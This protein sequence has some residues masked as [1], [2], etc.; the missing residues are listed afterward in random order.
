M[1]VDAGWGNWLEIN[2]SNWLTMT[3]KQDWGGL[4]YYV[5][6][7]NDLLS[8]LSMCCSGLTARSFQ[9]QGI[10]AFLFRIFHVLCKK[11]DDFIVAPC[12]QNVSPHIHAIN[13]SLPI[14][15]NQKALAHFWRAQRWSVYEIPS[16]KTVGVYLQLCVILSFLCPSGW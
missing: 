1:R 9:V 6:T 3:V 5:I 14:E 15:G 13:S 12:D 16:C 8:R 4:S 2:H 10:Q 11:M 7:Q